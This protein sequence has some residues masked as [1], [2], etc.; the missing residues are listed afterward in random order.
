MDSRA[1]AELACILEATARKPGNAFL[2]RDLDGLTCLQLLRSA[3]AVGPVIAEVRKLGIGKTIHE[4]VLA[5]RQV[6]D[7]N[8]NLGIL[9]LLVPLAYAA[10]SGLELDRLADVLNS[11]DV[12]AT[13]DVY[14]AIRAAR[15]GGM[16][17][18]A[19]QD[20][21]DTPTLG[22]VDVMR[23]AEDRDMI[24]CQYARGFADVREVGIPALLEPLA[25]GRSLEE[26]IC[27]CHLTW[28]ARFPD[29]L[30]ARKSGS[31]EARLAA[32]MA[33]DLLAVLKQR[34]DFMRD[35]ELLQLDRWL[36]ENGMARNPGT[37]ADLVT[38]C[39]FWGLRTSAIDMNKVR[40][41][42]RD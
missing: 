41:G 25:A 20:L 33:G 39:L 37:S 15:P 27:L 13:A 16:K 5:T 14:E 17:K 18:V 42:Q 9:L 38:A 36:T 24:A 28:M 21:A 34:K 4:A 35:A 22:L 32:K 3:V 23:L 40:F 29:S 26:S 1:A 31:T 7:T 11:L 10:D 12:S 6:V 2:G 19:E 8:T 30:I